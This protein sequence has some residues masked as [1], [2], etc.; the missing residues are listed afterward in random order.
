MAKVK[1]VNNKLSSDL[2]GQN[3]V[4]T[5]TETVFSLGT[6]NITSNFTGRKYTDYSTKLKSFANA[7]TLENLGVITSGDSAIVSGITDNIIL[8]LD[9]GD[10][11]SYVRFGS[12][13]ELMRV[14][15][16]NIILNYPASLFVNSKV[17]NKGNITFYDFSYDVVTNT[18]L[19]YIPSD[20]INNNYSLVFDDGNTSL[21]LD[22]VL[23]NLNLSFDKFCIWNKTINNDKFFN[24]IGFTGDSSNR[25]YVRLQCEGNPFNISG[26]TTN[27]SIDYHIRPNPETYNKEIKKLKDIERYFLKNR[28]NDYSGFEITLKKIL[29]LDDG[30]VDYSDTLYV[31]PTTDGYNI[32]ISNSKYNFFV[33][34]LLQIGVDY[35]D[36][37]TDLISR[38]LTTTSLKMYDQTDATKIKKLLRTYGAEFDKIR[39][40]IDS[41]V[42]I[43][44]ISYDKVKNTPDILVKNLARTLGWNTFTITNSDDLMSS[45]LSTTKDDTS[46]SLLPAEIDIELWRRIILNSNYYWKSKGTRDAIIS[47]LLLIGVPE[48]FINLTE[49]VY[50][51]DDVINVNNVPLTLN[52][53]PS[54]SLPY[55]SNG[56]P[57][58]PTES[59]SFFFQISGTNDAGKYYMDNFRNVG[60]KLNE[61]IDNKKSWPYGGY[62]Q[63]IDDL[64]PTYT[65]KDSKLVLNTKVIDIGLDAASAVE[66]D[67][68]EYIKNVDYP[69]SSTNYVVDTTFINISPNYTGSINSFTLPNTPYG[70]VDVSFNGITLK[71]RLSGESEYDYELIGNIITFVSGEFAISSRNDI[72]TISYLYDENGRITTSN[73]TYVVAIPTI[74]NS[75]TILTLP[76]IPL[77]DVQLSVNGIILTETTDSVVG[78]F[79]VNPTDSTQLIMENNTLANMLAS[80]PI[81]LLT[82]IH[83]LTTVDI[84][85]YNE[86]HKINSFNTSKFYYKLGINKYVYK[87]DNRVADTKN[88]KITL[89]GITLKPNVDYSLI[90]TFGCEIMFNTTPRMGDIIGAFYVVRVN[91]GNDAIIGDEFGVGDISNLSFTEFMAV[92]QKRMINAKNRQTI[93]NNVGGFYPNLL[94]IYVD[95][96]NRAN[97]TG[98]TLQSNGYTYEVLMNF[99]S[100]YGRVFD[101]FVETLIPATVIYRNG[102]SSSSSSGSSSGSEGGFVGGVTIRNLKFTR[103]KHRFLRG[104]NFN[105]EYRG[106]DGAIFKITQP[107]ANY[108]CILTATTSIEEIWIETGVTCILD[109]DLTSP[110]FGQLLISNIVI[111]DPS[112]SNNLI[113]INL[114]NNGGDLITTIPF[115]SG[116]SIIYEGLPEGTYIVEIIDG[117]STDICEISK[118]VFVNEFIGCGLDFN[119]S[120]PT[121]SAITISDI[122]ISD[123]SGDLNTVNIQ[124]LTTGDT[125]IET[126]VYSGQTT[127]NRTGYTPNTYNIKIIDGTSTNLCEISKSVEV[128]GEAIISCNLDFDLNWYPN[129]VE[130]FDVGTGFTNYV[131]NI[132]EVDTNYYVVGNMTQFGSGVTCHK[133]MSLNNNGSINDYFDYTTGTPFNYITKITHNP[134]DNTYLIVGD[135][136]Y[137]NNVYGPT[138]IRK[139]LPNGQIDDSFNVNSYLDGHV[140]G[141]DA[142]IIT[143]NKYLIG[144]SFERFGERYI[145]NNENTGSTVVNGIV[146]I[147]FNGYMDTTFNNGGSG[148]SGGTGTSSQEH[149]HITCI[150]DDSTNSRYIVGGYFYYYNNTTS[151]NII[152]LNYDGSIDTGFNI[153]TGFDGHVETI[154]IDSDGKYVVGGYFSLYNGVSVGSIVKLNTNGTINNT[155]N[156]GIRSI[157]INPITQQS[158]NTIGTVNTIIENHEGD[159]I[160]GGRFNT[161]NNTTTS[162]SI[163]KCDKTGTV[164]PIFS[165]GFQLGDVYLDTAFGYV[166][167]I[168][169]DSNQKYM[170]GGL[171]TRYDKVV[172]PKNI[173]RLN[174]DGTPD[175]C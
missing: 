77:G 111:S 160:I 164:D 170:V 98:S 39:T 78:D 110:D 163:C 26:I 42:Y 47:I 93:T 48:Q 74:T 99:I 95:Y 36:T 41:I 11:K 120:S 169:Q 97:L 105:S 123:P 4:N 6:F 13:E 38:M 171:F 43:N 60:F 128:I 53:L 142:C 168:Y 57:I 145:V 3:F 125:I 136:Y 65:Q 34:S 166:Y 32:D 20:Y 100:K 96:L 130:C 58:A 126:I 7:Y 49:Y 28:S 82:Y 67:F 109:F 174:T 90:T 148:F 124:I 50:T 22:S 54:A 71:P 91:Q 116:T 46:D 87:L 52:D 21:P 118:S 80:N 51:V 89:N 137:Y 161:F 40:F 117:T 61:T 45:I 155:Y 173:I 9:F 135:F 154:L 76:S 85:K 139:L 17:E 131:K 112:Q 150:A 18:S 79:R 94:K 5:P 138:S 1:V 56:Y 127:I 158:I 141:A 75:G 107:D 8:N 14:T 133:I 103:Q 172:I 149:H 12:C 10:L 159:Y 146:R 59:N 122:I 30:S 175:I 167:D 23:K 104:V 157:F 29:Q 81:V 73:I 37:K 102:G 108:W 151:Y 25:N 72:V 153:G 35:D 119:V 162:S 106:D 27:G 114:K 129:V 63:R 134:I 147:D 152:A 44:R 2:I 64:N 88:I 86:Y 165:D 113:T 143:N 16:Q 19:F 140:S 15:I 24:I 31:W 92:I 121:F 83:N 55:D 70:N 33:G 144:G 132:I 156:G 68:Y 115:T 84:T 69:N 66:N 101:K 62:L